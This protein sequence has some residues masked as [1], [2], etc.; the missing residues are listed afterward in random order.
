MLIT[1]AT[2]VTWGRPNQ[3]LDSHALLVTDGRIAALGP[4]AEL[5]NRAPRTSPGSTPG[6]ST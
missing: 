2:V 3:I 4:S 6:A 1:D 5:E